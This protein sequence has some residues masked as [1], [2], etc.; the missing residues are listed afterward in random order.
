MPTPKLV[1]SCTTGSPPW[2]AT[3]G[4]APTSRLQALGQEGAA[5]ELHRLPVLGA[6]LAQVHLP[7]VGRELRLLV[8]A[9]GLANPAILRVPLDGPEIGADAA[10]VGGYEETG[11]HG[12]DEEEL[13]I[14]EAKRRLARTLGVDPSSV[15]ITIEA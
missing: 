9:A 15:R 11:S 13:T 6:P 2:P 12:A 5:E 7:E 8:A 4:T 3:R 14:A 1:W 10:E